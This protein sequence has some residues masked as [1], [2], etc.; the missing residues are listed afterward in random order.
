M[1]T[2]PNVSSSLASMSDASDM[3]ARV[4]GDADS[5]DM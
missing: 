3:L 5:I 2:D 4:P 1:L